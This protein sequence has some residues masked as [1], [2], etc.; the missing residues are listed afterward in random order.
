MLRQLPHKPK[1]EPGA[2]GVERGLSQP[3]QAR[4]DSGLPIQ[5]QESLGLL[6]L[7]QLLRQPRSP[8][9]TR[10]P[11]CRFVFIFPLLSRGTG[12]CFLRE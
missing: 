10:Y 5:N 1:R 11:F 4:T 8:V 7:R 2:E 3:Q 9:T 6:R 12:R